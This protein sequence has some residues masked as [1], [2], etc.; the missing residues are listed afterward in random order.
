MSGPAA[1]L[2]ASVRDLRHDLVQSL[3]DA[4]DH[5]RLFILVPFSIIAGLIAYASLDQEPANWA[6]WMTGAVL[7]ASLLVALRRHSL[8]GVRMLGQ[9]AALW[10]GFCLL[11]LHGALFGTPML[12]Y[13]A[14]GTYQAR[15][16]AIISA[17]DQDQRV[18]VSG[19]TPVADARPVTIRRARLLLPGTP[20]L[21]PGDLVQGALRL[22]PIPGPVLPGSYDGQFHSYFSGIGAYGSTTSGFRRVAEGSEADLAR[23][24]QAMRD[25]IGG[26]IELALSGSSAAV[27]KA[28]VVGDQSSITD[29][30]RQV[31]A[32][33]GLAHIYSIS[34]LHLSIVAGGVFWLCRLILASFGGTVTWPVKKIA[35]V[36]GLAAAFGY[37]LLAGG[38]GNVP[39][40]RSTLMLALVFGAVLAGRR[41]LTMRNVAIAALVIVLLDPASVLRPSFQLSFAAVVGLIGIYE[42]PRRGGDA[43]RSGPWNRLWNAVAATA[44]TSFIAGAATLLFS[45]YH[46]QQTAPLGVLGNVMAFPFVTFVIMPFGV[47]AVLAMPF[48]L[49]APFLAIMGWGIDR[50]MDVATLVAGWSAQITGNPL[51]SSW[52][53][54]LGFG[55]LAWFALLEGRWRLLGPAVAVP[56]VLGFGFEPRPDVL[57]ADTTQAVAI[58][59]GEDLSLASGRLGS[60]AVNVWNQHYQTSIAAKHSGARCDDL[61]CIVT[62]P[63]YS[64]AIVRNAA[65]FAEDCF[66]VSLV[67]TRIRPPGWCNAS[68]LIGPDELARGGVHWLHWDKG[69]GRFDIRPAI[70]TV[71]RPWRVQPR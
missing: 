25:F 10:L 30:T 20:R 66:G 57:V 4:I 46:F 26:R 19:I 15:V 59:D 2:I 12:A 17:D 33:A 14:Y 23:R 40:F 42:M 11:P 24:V 16:D 35:A 27:G 64:I 70:V 71:S 18:V 69:A 38:T 51:L 13:P 44:W 34:G 37:L 67:I 52:T 7:L 55:A 9:G 49:D 22:A 5:R 62:T 45:A 48:G 28:M 21:A 1:H 56:L 60:F 65:A 43:R 32:A 6:L 54:V 39:A 50:M 58:R 68:P 3:G 47:L 53:L 8:F 61:G 63:E 41:A 31:M 29:E 36:A